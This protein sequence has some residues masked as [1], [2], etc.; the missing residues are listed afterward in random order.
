VARRS[1]VVGGGGAYKMSAAEAFG[2]VS[3]LF[4]DATVNPCDVMTSCLS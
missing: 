4:G 2:G 1:A 3:K